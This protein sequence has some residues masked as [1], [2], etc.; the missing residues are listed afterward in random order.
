M[1]ALFIYLYPPPP[2]PSVLASIILQYDAT[3]EQYQMAL[4]SNVVHT[5]APVSRH[6][7]VPE[8]SSLVL[9]A[10]GREPGSRGNPYLSVDS[11]MAMASMRKLLAV[12]AG[13][14]DA[15]IEQL[16]EDAGLV[17]PSQ[18]RQE[19]SG[20]GEVGGESGGGSR[21]G[22]GDGHGRNDNG[23]RDAPP[24]IQTWRCP[25]HYQ[26]S[27]DGS[28]CERIDELF[29]RE[30]QQSHMLGICLAGATLLWIAAFFCMYSCLGYK[31]GCCEYC[32]LVCRSIR[33]CWAR[34]VGRGGG[35]RMFKSPPGGPVGLRRVD[36]AN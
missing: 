13:P 24:I 20:S 12:A 15:L 21:N 22:D 14:A 28:T 35:N 32:R 4:Q 27:R 25:D 9:R 33:R 19:R 34:Q 30:Y 10:F 17:K 7:E 36:A 8:L 18:S 1:C 11:G 16:N 29:D 5:L 31:E 26:P 23:N 3:Y 2:H 6:V